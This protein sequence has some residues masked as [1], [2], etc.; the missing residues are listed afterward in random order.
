MRYQ[1]IFYSIGISF[2]PQ[3]FYIL[4]L[5]IKQTVPYSYQGFKEDILEYLICTGI[6]AKIKQK[7]QVFAGPLDLTSS[8]GLIPNLIIKGICFLDTLLAGI[9]IE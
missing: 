5:T 4:T 1:S 3:L 6:G 2:L 9:A 8:M 7:F